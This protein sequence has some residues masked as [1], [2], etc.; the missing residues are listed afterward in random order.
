MG[1]FRKSMEECVNKRR[2]PLIFKS[3]T[4]RI[5]CFRKKL[6]VKNINEKAK[7]VKFRYFL[8]KIE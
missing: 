2:K 3:L 6:M 8:M 7:N 4:K 5:S 1:G